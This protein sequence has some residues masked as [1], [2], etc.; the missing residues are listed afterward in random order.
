MEVQY[1]NSKI[2]EI[3]TNPKI[4]RKEYGA[5]MAG[6]IRQRIGQLSAADS[7]DILIQYHI[8]RCH[9]LIGD[10]AGQ[11]AMDLEQ[12]YRLIFIQGNSEIQI[13]EVQEIIDY[14]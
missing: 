9:R 10:R 5:T 13:V 7:V 2:Q 3:C 12:P 8:G 14:H 1:K 6:K 11:C 4:A